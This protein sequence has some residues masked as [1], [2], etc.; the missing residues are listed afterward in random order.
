M[1]GAFSCPLVYSKCVHTCTHT[2]APTYAHAHPPTGCPLSERTC[3]MTPY[4]HP[5]PLPALLPTPSS[6][7]PVV[8]KCTRI[9]SGSKPQHTLNHRW[10]VC[11][12][13]KT[14]MLLKPPSPLKASSFLVRSGPSRFINNAAPSPVS[15]TNVDGPVLGRT[16]LASSGLHPCFSG[17]GLG[18]RATLTLCI[19]L[20]SVTLLKAH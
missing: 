11:V 1:G 10:R 9:I 13:S 4:R 17:V 16:R 20:G 19:I 18:R 2:H 8:S 14:R 12:F 15:M 6:P 5:I 7:T 3:R